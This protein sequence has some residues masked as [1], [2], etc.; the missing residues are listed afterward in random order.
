MMIALLQ[1]KEQLELL[2]LIKKQNLVDWSISLKVNG[3]LSVTKVLEIPK[4]M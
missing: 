3:E 4:L 2:I 1:K